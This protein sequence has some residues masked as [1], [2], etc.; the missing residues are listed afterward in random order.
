MLVSLHRRQP[1]GSFPASEPLPAHQAGRRGPLHLTHPARLCCK[2]L[3]LQGTAALAH[4]K[5]LLCCDPCQRCLAVLAYM[6]TGWGACRITWA[7][8]SLHA[9]LQ[10]GHSLRRCGAGA[11][12][13]GSKGAACTVHLQQMCQ[14]HALDRDLSAGTCMASGALQA[15]PPLSDASSCYLYMWSEG[16]ALCLSP[17]P[18]TL[19]AGADCANWWQG[20]ACGT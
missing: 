5:A 19:S 7:W 14:L 4:P 10:L 20:R 15:E 17:S 16:V 9:I 3:S 11:V 8:R 12:V 2:W 18:L 1:S 6:E 13:G